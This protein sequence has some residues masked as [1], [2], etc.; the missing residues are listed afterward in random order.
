MEKRTI[1]ITGA[2]SGFGKGAA[3]ELAARGHNVIAATETQAQADAL[4]AEFPNLT[5]LKLDVTSS[6]DIARVP[7]LNV[8]V[9]IN[10]AGLGVMAPMASVPMERVRAAF[11][12]ALQREP[13]DGER[14]DFTAYA[15]KHGLPAM[16]RVLFNSN[17]F[18]FVN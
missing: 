4:A 13:T 8:D 10:N 6:D 17:E 16:G 2:G 12:L 3:V 5:T 1:L 11:R 18:L 7:G 9:L 15:I 14:A